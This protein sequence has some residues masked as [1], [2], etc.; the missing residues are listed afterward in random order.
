MDV[1]NSWNKTLKQQL[2]INVNHIPVNFHR[3]LWRHG[4]CVW[5]RVPLF[6]GLSFSS[7]F[8]HRLLLC[9]VH[10][11]RDQQQPQWLVGALS[12]VNH[13]GLH[14]GWKQPQWHSFGEQKRRWKDLSPQGKRA[15]ASYLYHL[16]LFWKHEGPCAVRLSFTKNQWTA[17]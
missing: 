6:S 15:W 12:P 13:R 8:V 14:Q 3:V 2:G 5:S 16:V 4:L 9:H 1:V 17:A 11:H 7:G 10:S